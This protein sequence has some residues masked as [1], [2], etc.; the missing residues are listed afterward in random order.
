[1]TIS[2]RDIM[3]GA[4]AAQSIGASSGAHAQTMTPKR[5][6]PTGQETLGPFFPVRIPPMH[7]QDITHYPGRT[8]RAKGQII[9]L[10]GRVTDIK[11]RPLPEAQILIWQAN[12]AGRYVNPV[13]DNP[14]PIDPDF[15]GVT[16]FG[17]DAQGRYRLRSVKPG[18]YPEPSGTMRT[19]HIHFDV[20]N[21]DYRLVAQMYFP[22]EALN[23]HDILLSTLASRHR[24]P[25]DAI[26]RP[27]KTSEPNVLA[28]EWNIVL[29]T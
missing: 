7:D 11:G 26:C 18:A 15:Q 17:V 2:R 28:F 22:G 10:T 27:A 9:E 19:P 3:A 8:G 20:T 5:L 1:M 21:A 14:A 6:L 13:D 24:K 25:E 12:A 16:S 23:A 4:I 29:L